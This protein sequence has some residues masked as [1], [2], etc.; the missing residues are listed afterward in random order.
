[1]GCRCPRRGYRSPLQH[2]V[3]AACL[4]T[5]YAQAPRSGDGCGG[6]RDV[7]AGLL[8][9][10]IVSAIATGVPSWCRDAE[11]LMLID[12][13]DRRPLACLGPVVGSQTPAR[14]STPGSTRSTRALPAYPGRGTAA[15]FEIGGRDARVRNQL[16]GLWEVVLSRM[17]PILDL[18][19]GARWRVGVCGADPRHRRSAR[20]DALGALATRV[21]SAGVPVQFVGGCGG[22]KARPSSAAGIV[23][24][25]RGPNRWA[26]G[27]IRTPPCPASLS[28]G[29]AIRSGSC[30]TISPG[31]GPKAVCHAVDPRSLSGVWSFRSAPGRTDPGRCP[32]PAPAPATLWRRRAP[33]RPSHR[34]PVK[35]RAHAGP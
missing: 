13:R 31:P 18:A 35:V 6:R 1:M 27:T 10:R 22:T 26:A 2:R 34:S 23:I 14:P 9:Y 21:R 3:T 25:H 30:A 19:A 8:S 15:R 5:E 7:P 33:C 24:R 20:A 12:R 29:R 17:P 16:D 4:R 11:G 32:E 28:P